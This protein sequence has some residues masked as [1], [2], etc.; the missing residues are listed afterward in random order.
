MDQVQILLQQLRQNYLAEMPE[1][2]ENLE[3]LILSMERGGYCQETYNDLYRQVHS[4]KGSGGTYGMQVL[5][6]I[7]HPFEDYLSTIHSKSDV[8]AQGFANI[9]LGYVDLMRQVSSRLEHK[10]DAELDIDLP[11][12]QLRQRAFA[13]RYSAL[14]V[15]NSTTVIKLIGRVL[16]AHSVRAVVQ[17][18]GYQALGRAL[19]EKF[20]LLITAQEIKQVNGIALITAVKLTQGLNQHMKTILLMAN[21]ALPNLAHQPDYVLAKDDQLH[22]RLHA[23]LQ[24][25][26]VS[27]AAQN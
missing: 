24:S 15:E 26:T 25:M 8:S 13:P 9:A 2:L 21:P 19:A 1:R 6:S 3:N 5:T 16:Q 27:W 20:D 11:L 14:L 4:L 18:D 22:V 7:C 12:D 17:D 10:P 23:I